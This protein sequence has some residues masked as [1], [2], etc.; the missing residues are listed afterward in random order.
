MIHDGEYLANNPL[1]NGSACHTSHHLYFNYNCGQFF[2]LWGRIGGSYRKADL[3]WFDRDKKMSQQTWNDNVKKMRD[4]Q[5][6]VRE[7]PYI[8]RLGGQEQLTL[9]SWLVTQ[10]GSSLCILDNALAVRSLHESSR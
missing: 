1:V 5:G 4:C 7:R 6:V 9:G 3:E 10:N 2:T 8:P